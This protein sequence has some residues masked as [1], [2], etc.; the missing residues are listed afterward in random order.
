MRDMPG[1]RKEDDHRR[2]PP[3]EQLADRPEGFLPEKVK[4]FEVW[5]PCR[6]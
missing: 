1:L 3:V 6:R 2:F 5:F 4:P